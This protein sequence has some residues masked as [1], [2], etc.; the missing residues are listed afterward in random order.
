MRNRS[1]R[2]GTVGVKLSGSS[3][4]LAHLASIALAIGLGTTASL[5]QPFERD[6]APPPEAE[7]YT[8][9]TQLTAIGGLASA[10]VKIDALTGQQKIHVVRWTPAGNVVWERLAD[11]KGNSVPHS[12]VTFGGETIIAGETDAVGGVF[13]LFVI[14]LDA[15]GNL[16]WGF[17][18]C[19]TPFLSDR[20]TVGLQFADNGDLLVTGRQ[21]FIGGTG[22]SGRLMRLG[23]AGNV[24]FSKVFSDA[25]SPARIV[26]FLDVRDT[27][28][29]GYWVL[30]DE[31]AAST[32]NNHTPFL[33][34][35]DPAGNPIFVRFYP[36]FGP[37]FQADARAA[38]L[39]RDPLTG[40]L[41]VS[42]RAALPTPPG[43]VPSLRLF[44][45]DANGN[46][47][48]DFIY[49]TQGPFNPAHTA[50]AFDT[51]AP[52]AL[53]AGTLG[54]LASNTSRASVVAVD[55]AGGAFMWGQQYGQASLTAAHDLALE[56][57]PT[58]SEP[59]IAGSRRALASLPESVYL[60]R[61][62]T[63]GV[64][65]CEEPFAALQVLQNIPAETFF[66]E[67]D[68]QEQAPF[69]PVMIALSSPLAT[70]CQPCYADCDGNGI[71]DVNDFICFQTFFAINDPYADCDNNLIFDINDFICF[72]TFFAIGC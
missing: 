32:A 71:L 50:V 22:R 10:G 30:G 26:Q 54:G 27:Q 59:V 40:H 66:N 52:R 39:D 5:A 12:L 7:H 44:R 6:L 21:E 25:V 72:Q 24:L 47:L 70:P 63:M 3:V 41:I 19:G 20:R 28:G 38:G 34:R 65:G 48:W 8:V 4:R 53:V 67:F 56:P 42:S 31:R 60:V 29:N 49:D 23:P 1:I 9:G 68:C 51:L 33:L 35:T 58:G 16:Q 17:V 36:V 15:A 11:I 55:A 14:R 43:P 64:T 57:G 2:V 61:A 13:G 62:D 37:P 18:Y 69:K 45:T 46:P